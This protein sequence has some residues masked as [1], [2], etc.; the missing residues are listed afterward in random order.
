MAARTPPSMATLILLT[1]MGILSLN[2]FAPSLTHIAEDFGADYGLVSL[3]IGGYLAIT[4]VLQ[5]I[6][7]PLSDRYGRRPVLLF[8]MAIFTVASVGCYLAP[9]VEIFLGFRLLQ[10]AVISGMALSRAVIRDIVPEKEAASKMGY[11]N[12]AVAVAPMI[13]PT[14]GGFLDELFGWRANF[15]TYAILGA[16]LTVLAWQDLGET[17]AHK[18]ATFRAQFEAY[19]ELFKSRRF[20]GYSICLAF[21]VSGFYTF[22]AGAPLVAQEIFGMSPSQLGLWMGTITLGFFVTSFIAGRLSGRFALT[23]MM[24]AGRILTCSGLFLG[25]C[26][27]LAGFVHPYVFFASTVFVGMGNGLTLPSANVGAMSVRPQLAGSASGLSGAL[28][29]GAGAV[30]TTVTGASLTAENGAW[31]LVGILLVTAVIGL[32]SAWYVR[33]LDARDAQP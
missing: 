26:I 15:A 14:F 22:T 32:V 18:S 29:V 8:G 33:V 25:F 13:A 7:G 1:A 31:M 23:T 5:L 17:N 2:M 3:S 4:A 28:T 30:V 24:M 20:W 21:S 27:L 12:M 19:P 11:I 6:L 9:T 10:G 16:G